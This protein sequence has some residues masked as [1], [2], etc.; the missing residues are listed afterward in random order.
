M[1][2]AH[3]VTINN[4]PQFCIDRK[5]E[6]TA[7]DWANKLDRLCDKKSSLNDNV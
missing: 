6:R 3:K 5:N 1:L 4:F 7:I 2:T